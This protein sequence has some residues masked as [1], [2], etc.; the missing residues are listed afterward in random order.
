MPAKMMV[1]DDPDLA[2]QQAAMIEAGYCGAKTRNPMAQGPFCRQPAGK[3]TDHLGTGRCWLHGGISGSLTH[4]RY[5]Q[6]KTE[7]IDKLVQEFI[8]DPNPLNTG[9][10][11]AMARALLTDYINRYDLYTEAL[12]AWYQSFLP[13]MPHAL[14]LESLEVV[15]DRYTDHYGE[16]ALQQDVAY[17]NC[18][19]WIKAH[20]K[21][22]PKPTQLLDLGEAVKYADTVTKM[23]ERVGKLQNAQAISRKDF[24]RIMQ[25]IG[26]IIEQCVADDRTK[27]R[28]KDRFGSLRLG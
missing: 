26:N 11:I 6:V 1:P 10:E 19:E 16:E 7:R 17:I 4:G 12:L 9:P 14:F 20:K 15:L 5:S 23:T 3:N 24:A 22:L 2:A 8:D 21:A 27:L 18:R 28:I 25:E 13:G